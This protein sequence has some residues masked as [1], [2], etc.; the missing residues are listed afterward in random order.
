MS[1][2]I[3]A[4]FPSLLGGGIPGAQ[5]PSGLIGGGGGSWW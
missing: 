2:Q 1:G 4:I 3:G 5:P